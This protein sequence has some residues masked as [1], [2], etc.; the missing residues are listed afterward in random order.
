MVPN[1]SLEELVFPK[2]TILGV[3]EGVSA[4]LVA[5]INDGQKAGYARNRRNNRL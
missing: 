1:F 4:G 2:A 5:A 3:G